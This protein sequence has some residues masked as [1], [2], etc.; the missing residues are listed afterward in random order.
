MNAKSEVR[1]AQMVQI[2]ELYAV[3]RQA[4]DKAQEA[5]THGM[6]E[7][8]LAA[9]SECLVINGEMVEH[10][11]DMHHEARRM[12]TLKQEVQKVGQQ[13]EEIR[14]A[15]QNSMDEMIVANDD[16]LYSQSNSAVASV[17]RTKSLLWIL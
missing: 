1:A 14:V 17:E 8:A 2:S 9:L 16:E 12:H 3:Y 11:H 10:F 15:F 4:L 5:M 13:M 7:A 6:R